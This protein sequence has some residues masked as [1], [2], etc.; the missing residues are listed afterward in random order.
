MAD[1]DLRAYGQMLTHE[2]RISAYTEAIRAAVKPGAVV[3]DLGTGTGFMALLACQYGAKRVYALEPSDAILV[4]QQAAKDNGFADRIVFQRAFST[5]IELPEKCGV[6]LSDLRG[7]TPCFTTHL[8]DVMD[9][10]A[11]LLTPNAHCICQTD[12]LFVSVTDMPDRNE[13]VAAQWDGSRWGLDLSSALRFACNQMSRHRCEPRDLLG[14]PQS[15]ARI[16]YPTLTSPHVRGAAILSI[17]RD[18]PAHG[19]EVWF[20]AELFGGTRFSNAPDQPAGVYTRMFLPWEKVVM[21]QSGDTVEVKLDVVF[22]GHEYWWNWTS[23]VRRE[24]HQEPVA[25]FKQSTFK[26]QILST[27]AIAHSSANHQPVLTPSGKETKFVLDR[28][29][30]HMTQAELATA[31]RA[32]FPE[33]FPDDASAH[34]RVSQICRS[35]AQ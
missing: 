15:W 28:I 24:G 8:V 17:T 30:D 33:R 19:L 1:Y 2:T 16:H 14:P 21:L 7:S 13:Q 26:G 23:T 35:F 29:D 22:S 5:Q 9:A 18:G 6:L 25:A 11:R 20:E 31:L 27:A 10:R 3:L 12:T 4:A 32:K 34:A